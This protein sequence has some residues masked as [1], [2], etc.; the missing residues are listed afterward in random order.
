M[1]YVQTF[2]NYN[3]TILTSSR[4][5]SLSTS[6][7]QTNTLP[8]MVH[9]QAF[10]N[11]N[12][13]IPTSSNDLSLSTSSLQTRYPLWS[14]VRLSRIITWQSPPHRE[15]L[16]YPLALSKHYPLW[17]TVRLSRIITWQSPPHQEASPYQSALSKHA[18]HYGIRSGFHVL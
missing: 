3:M 17:Y 14:T 9:G 6:S 12:M 1:L 11:Y 7:I 10:T 4:V 13:I 5:L 2:T 16:P 18:T 8:S 15:A